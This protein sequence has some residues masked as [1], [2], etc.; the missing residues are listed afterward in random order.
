MERSETSDFGSL[1]TGAAG[2]PPTSSAASR[3]STLRIVDRTAM[4]DWLR[5]HRRLVELEADF[6]DAAMRA[7]AGKIGVDELQQKHD[8]LMGMRDL[9][10]A[11]YEKAFGNL[12]RP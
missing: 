4:Q 3:L 9:S 6:S 5:I 10:T 11:V 12:R 8:L 1:D 7:A 2:L